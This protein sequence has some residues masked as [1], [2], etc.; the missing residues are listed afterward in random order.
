MPEDAFLYT[1]GKIV[2][3][4]EKEIGDKKYIQQQ[5]D[6]VLFPEPNA[7]TFGLRPG[8]HFHYKAQREK[9]GFFN[10]FMNKRIGEEPVYFSE[11]NIENTENVLQNRLENLGHFRS[12]VAYEIEVDSSKRQKSITYTIQLK[13]AYKMNSFKLDPEQLDSILMFKDIE[14]SLTESKI[15][16]KS[17][18]DLNL[19]KEER[20]RIHTHLKERGYYNF[21][22]NFLLFEIDTNQYKDKGF[23]LYLRLKN[24]VPDEALSIYKVNEVNVFPNVG[25]SSSETE[26][27]I[28]TVRVD[29]IN[30]LQDSLYFKPERLRPFILLKEGAHYQP[31][32]SRS[33]SRRLGSI[34]TYKFVNIEYENLDSLDQDN[35]R[36]LNAKISLSPLNKRS[37]RFEVQ[38]VTKSNNFTGPSLGTTYINRN[39]FKAGEQ[40]RINAS[41]GYERQFLSGDQDGLSSLQLGLRSSLSIPRLLFPIDL[42][43]SFKYSVPKTNIGLGVDLLDRTNLYTLSSFS[44]SFGYSWEGNRYVTHKINPLNV[45]YLSLQNTSDDFEEILENNPFLRRS[46]EQQF[47]AGLNYS[48]TYNA[49]PDQLKSDGMFFNFNFD[50]AGNTLDLLAGGSERPNTFLDL[51]YAQ[52]VKADVDLRY[53]VAL[54]SKGQKLVGRLFAGAGLPY[55]NSTSL[56]FVKQ[57]FAGGPYSVRGF[58]IRSL[59]PGTYEPEPGTTSF[60]DQAGDIRL[61]ANLEYRF[62]IIN[63]LNGA[64]FTDAGNVWLMNENP[65][66]PGGKFTSSFIGEFGVSSGFGL[67]VDIAGFVIRFDLAAPVKRPARTW[68]FEYDS[69]VLNFAIGY[70]F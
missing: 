34:N 64:F 30:F 9:P 18:F 66:L 13:E 67:R 17:R 43:S 25:L 42:S 47:I 23:D 55:A 24:E 11:V 54:D 3:E 2:L 65:S 53:H 22:P 70:P 7:S 57:Y 48:F 61:E 31:S 41:I 8:L 63:F 32:I 40:L 51:A 52:Y 10:K 5:V 45:E 1:G 69:P 12:A 59:G 16:N 68:N 62:P 33:T 39:L 14:K 36:W 37:I 56:P 21:N 50:S 19:L 4:S 35:K 26:K 27:K 15:N 60:F 29:G 46:F 20:E 49:I 44:G 58:R 6:E 28:D 38:G